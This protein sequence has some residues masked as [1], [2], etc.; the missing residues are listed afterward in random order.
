M[1]KSGA[2]R[3]GPQE[4][5]EIILEHPSVQ[6]VA[7]FGMD[8]PILGESIAACVIIESGDIV[9]GERAFASLPAKPSVIQGAAPCVVF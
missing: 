1:I 5:E 6:E 4:I 8:D 9:H 3:I 7:V 2:H